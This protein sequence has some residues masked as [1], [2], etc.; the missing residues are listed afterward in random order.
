MT[1]TTSTGKK[2]RI[3]R[4]TRSR[5]KSARKEPPQSLWKRLNSIEISAKKIKRAELI[6][7]SRELSTLIDS[8][9]GIESA[10]NL[11][12]E[13]RVG[14]AFEPIINQLKEDLNA[15]K[16]IAESMGNQPKVFPRVYVRTVSSADRGAPLNRT[17]SQAADFLDSAQSAIAQAKRAMI[18][19][20]MIVLVGIGVVTMLLTVSLPQM[21]GLF[22]TMG[23]GLPMPTKVL[24]AISGFLTGYPLHILGGLVGGVFAIMKIA[25]SERGTRVIHKAMLRTPMLGQIV[26]GGDVS[27][28]MGAL[29]SLSEVGLPLPEAMEVA[30]ETA[31]NMIVREALAEA[32]EGLVAGNGLSKPLRKSGLFPTTLIQSIRVAEDTGTLDE[33]LRRMSDFYQIDSSEK[34]KG[35]VGM[36]EPLATISV[37]LA[38]G[39]VAMAVIMP[40][41]S[42]LGSIEQ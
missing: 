34:V 39:F 32:R 37:A 20:A 21:I 23:A 7:F 31:S 29:A 41:Y 12:M 14:T 13:Q 9:I 11:L 25:K 1:T 6:S 35:M 36:I 17:L 28:A 4:S 27:R 30:Q 26:V 42:I 10:L 40:M 38:V 5:R 22:E 8:G 3:V 16:T 33:N 15:G 2:R 18:Y 24:I 19:P